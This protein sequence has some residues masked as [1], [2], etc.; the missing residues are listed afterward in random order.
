[1]FCKIEAYSYTREALDNL[2]KSGVLE[3]EPSH[4]IDLTFREYVA[5]QKSIYM[6]K[7]LLKA[8]LAI[9]AS[10]R[11]ITVHPNGDESSGQPVL[12]QDT[13]NG[14]AHV[15]AGAGGRLNGLKLNKIRSKEEYRQA[16]EEKREKEKLEKL[17]KQ[18][19]EQQAISR[20]TPDERRAYK[21]NKKLAKEIQAEREIEAK[22]KKTT[23]ES[24]FI[25]YMANKFGWKMIDYDE[26]TK[27]QINEI[28]K[29]ID[30]AE[31]RGDKDEEKR[32]RGEFEIAIKAR[33]RAKKSQRA[34]F[35][36][37][38]KEQVKN[39][40]RELIADP[41]LNEQIHAML[42]EDSGAQQIIKK[43]NPDTSLGYKKDYENIAKEKGA[44]P[45]ELER[46]KK[47]LFSERINE[48]AAEN[49]GLAR[50]ITKG[51]ETN[52]LINDAK[53]QIYTEEEAP[54]QSIQEVDQKADMLKKY[55]DMKKVLASIEGGRPTQINLDGTE[56]EAAESADDIVYGRG[57]SLAYTEMLDADIQ[58]EVEK[59]ITERQAALHSSLLQTINDNPGGSGKWIANGNYAGL[60]AISLAA[61]KLEGLDR[62]V[63]DILGVGASA[64]LL[65]MTAR[66]TMSL[67]AYQDFAKAMEKYHQATNETIARDALSRGRELLTRAESIQAEIDANPSD[68]AVLSE[69]NATRLSYLDEANRIVGQALGSLEAAA[70]MVVELKNMKDPT[71]IDVALGNISTEEAIIRM[72]ALG[73]SEEDYKINT[74][75]TTKVVTITKPEKLL[76]YGNP[77]DLRLEREVES[78]K[79]GLKDE[80]EWL[81]AGIVRRTTESFEDPG[82]NA[83]YASDSIEN[84]SL[85][86][87]AEEIA[88]AE[89]AVHRTL[90]ELPEGSFAFKDVADLSPEEQTDLRRYWEAHLYQG[91]Y[92]ERFSIRDMQSGKP[93]SRQAAWMKYVNGAFGG[94]KNAAFEAIRQDLIENHSTEDMFGMTEIPPLAQVVPGKLE[95]YRALNGARAL[96]QEIEDLRDPETVIDQEAAAKEADKLEKELPEKLNELYES[97]MREHYLSFMSGISEL[98]FDSSAERQEQTP[99]AEYVRMHGDVK[100][101][102]ASVLDSIRGDFSSRFVKNYGRVTKKKLRTKAEKIRN[103]QDHVLGMLDKDT[104]DSVIN[105]VQA[106]LASAGA[107]VANRINGKFATGAWKEKALQYLEEKKLADEAQGNLFGETEMKQE[108][109]TEILSLGERVNAQLA[110]IIPQIA[111]N[112]HRGQKYAVSHGMN[113]AGERQRAIKMFEAVKRM[114]LTFG[115]GKGK[116]ILS[117]ASFTDLKSKGKVK[118]GLYAVPSV[119]QEQFGNEINVFCE[120]GRYR[121]ESDPTLT[122]QS[123]FKH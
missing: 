30:E 95:T 24:E 62:D 40:Q 88:Q 12:I 105:K 71:T 3:I 75:N 36:A 28:Q 59:I 45:E 1:M 77:E 47:K 43:E 104:R 122:R 79:A 33:E 121:V 108:D 107:K 123:A 25:D 91:S 61:I 23:A 80:P 93:I 31:A 119:V 54:T 19:E 4:Y 118:R 85:G 60:N 11:W 48:I 89:E 110:S 113:T 8:K 51:V 46:E 72:H 53:N 5:M 69:L 55:L 115:T 98:Q 18:T 117:I 27:N 14:T 67:E 116:T 52:K 100:R 58:D 35:L 84:Q 29:K 41:S 73:L 63:V 103:W 92:A 21:E 78:I 38:A 109:K 74:I 97:Q 17:Q 82:P 10:A 65:A 15:I 13:G 9:P 101:A 68:L 20:M 70:A 26:E 39:I 37:A 66:K 64:K 6:A 50:M 16:V 76:T 83:E 34:N 86:E 87:N 94:D 56:E 42:G 32:L 22:K 7:R 99:W 81:P 111:I 112:Q 120:P 57:V 90:G 49:P 96:F 102:Q 106:E 2:R 114:N 44:S